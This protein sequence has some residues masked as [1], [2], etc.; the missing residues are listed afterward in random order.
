[1]EQLKEHDCLV[2]R[3]P[4][5]GRYLGWGFV[6]N[7]IRF[8]APVNARMISDDIDALA[9]MAVEGGGITRLAAFIAEPLIANGK[10]VALFTQKPVTSETITSALE[11]DAQVEIEPLEF[12]LCVRHRRELTP[13]VRA[14]SQFLTE[15]LPER[16]RA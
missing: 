11:A 16:W 10:L 15:T 9:Q 5:D 12:Y 2:F 6:R 3:F 13:K 1:M 14:F 8:D 7:G 4:L